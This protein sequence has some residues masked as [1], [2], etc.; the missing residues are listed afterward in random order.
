MRVLQIVLAPENSA[1]AVRSVIAIPV[2]NMLQ[3]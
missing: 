3:E 1:V 2:Y